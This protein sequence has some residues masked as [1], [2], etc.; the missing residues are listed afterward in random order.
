MKKS[1]LRLFFSMMILC[2]SISIMPLTVKAA[3]IPVEEIEIGGND[4]LAVGN[5]C[6]YTCKVT[7][8]NAS[9]SKVLWSVS[10]ENCG[11]TISAAGKVTVASNVSV[12]KVVITAKSQGDESIYDTKEICINKSA[13]RSLDL[14]GEDG[15]SIAGKKIYLCKAKAT[16]NTRTSFDI[17]PQITLKN[18]ES[19]VKFQ[20]YTFKSSNEN[21]VTVDNNGHVQVTGNETGTVTISCNLIDGSKGANNASLDKKI[22]FQVIDPVTEINITGNNVVAAGRNALFVATTNPLTP[23]IPGVTWEVMPAKQG[24]KI[25]ANGKLI[26]DATCKLDELEV[27]AK[28]KNNNDVIGKKTVLVNHTAIK[29]IRLMDDFGNTY[30]NQKTIKLYRQKV[31]E[32][33][34]T[35]IKLV[36][37]IKKVDATKEMIN[38]AFEFSSSDENIATVDQNGYVSVTGNKTGNVKIYCKAIDGKTDQKAVVSCYTNV[39]VV[40]PIRSVEISGEDVVIPKTDKTYTYSTTPVNADN[41]LVTWKVIPEN[42][43]VSFVKPGILHVDA[44][45]S[46]EEVEIQAISKENETVIGSK[47]VWIN[48]SN[49]KTLSLKDEDGNIIEG[50]IVQLFRN[51]PCEETPTELYIK[52]EI[53]WSNPEVT[54]NN[55]VYYTYTSSNTKLVN[56][57]ANGHVT[58]TNNRT[59]IED[60]VE[61]TCFAHSGGTN[62][63]KKFTV[64][65]MDAL[66]GINISLPVHR[67]NYIVKGQTLQLDVK[68][69][70]DVPALKGKGLVYTSSN[71]S[72]A[73]VTGKGLVK[74]LADSYSKVTITVAANDK[75]GVKA[76]I[77]L[78]GTNTITDMLLGDY[79][80]NKANKKY[81]FFLNE[82]KEEA[83]NL[84]FNGPNE[85]T[86]NLKTVCPDMEITSSNPEILEARYENGIVYLKPIKSD[87]TKNVTVTIQ[88][89]DGSK[90]AR[91]WTFRVL[92]SEDI[93]D[94]QMLMIPNEEMFDFEKLLENED[95][96]EIIEE[97]EGSNS[98]FDKE[99]LKEDDL[100]EYTE[101]KA[102]NVENEEFVEE[103][104]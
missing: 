22:T 12:D 56:V 30:T 72:V 102:E 32:K 36:P 95:T 19:E 74:M 7:P 23:T 16:E 79:P 82:G 91:T 29:E 104:N 68:R 46:L 14:V 103:D 43:G 1:N 38:T 49:A 51:K 40:E 50:K 89:M 48:K 98:I 24:A 35:D 27:I 10:P 64:K 77:D 69:L 25:D 65:A 18:N 70:M 15:K 17:R 76:S 71:P 67:S 81:M 83:L 60:A 75:S 57:D 84:K 101:E 63:S 62:L 61:I 37:V 73:T 54:S 31:N 4:L 33:M 34:V 85:G 11:V 45:C 42:S 59:T 26:I 78:Y 41:K 47:K 9:N 94:A 88:S 52:P 39:K 99:E 20:P 6:I 55:K 96:G 28:S 21:I 3:V 8:K 80:S 44:N 2:L 53:T 58:L 97:D 92:D 100:E 13:I 5:S 87:G 86:A 66:T 93:L 90:F